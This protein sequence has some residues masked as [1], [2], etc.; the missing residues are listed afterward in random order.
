M[1]TKKALLENLKSHTFCRYGPSDIDGIGIFAIK[2]I[3]KDTIVFKICNE[4][5][6]NIIELTD[7]DLEELDDSVSKYI[8]DIFIREE[9]GIWALPEC[10]LNSLNISFFLNH[11]NTPNLSPQMTHGYAA[12]VT[13][14]F[15]KADEE[16]TNDYRLLGSL[17]Q[18][19][20]QFPW[21]K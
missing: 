20:K 14:R 8:E 16:L 21:L 17:E 4:M 18:V 1:N 12:W 9:R 13:N 11:S 15:I 3:P 6:D 19:H 7:E 10:G 5:Y 2:S